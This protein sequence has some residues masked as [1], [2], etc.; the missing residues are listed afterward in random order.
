MSIEHKSLV[1]FS[2]SRWDSPPE[3]FSSII[4]QRNEQNARDRPPEEIPLPEP[5]VR[6]YSYIT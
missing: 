4:E 3:G 1:S 6:Y 2:E 5:Q